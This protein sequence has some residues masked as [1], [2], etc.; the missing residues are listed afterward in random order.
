MDTLIQI[1][2]L[3]A[4][5]LSGFVFSTISILGVD[6]NWIV[7]WLFTG[8]VF[9]TL[10]LGF[11]N[12]RGFSTGLKALRGDFSRTD[13]PG[14]LSP[15]EAL[16]T[17]LSATVGLGNIAGVAIAI[18][19]G[20]PGAAFWMIFIGFFA[21]SLKFAE[22]T[23]AV[24]YREIGVD[25]HIKGGPMYY[26]ERG[27]AEKGWPRFGR[28]MGILYA[29]FALIAFIQVIQVNQSW[30]QINVVLGLENDRTFALV[31]GMCIAT[32]VGLVLIGGVKGVARVTS[33]LTPLMCA[34]YLGSVAI[35]LAVNYDKIGPAM[36]T[37]VTSAFTSE[38]GLGGV[39]GAFVIGMRRAVYSNE[40]GIGSAAIAHATVKTDYPASEG[41]VAILEPFV[42]TFIVCAATAILIVSTGVWDEGY[43]D[44]AMT[45]AAFATVSSWFPVML[46]VC[47][48]VFAFSTMIAAGF[49]GR[50]LASYISNGREWFVNLYLVLFCALL[51][52]GAIV[53]FSTLIK[54]IDSLFFLLSVPN[55]V[56]L[57]LLTSVISV[58]IR[59]FRKARLSGEFS[60]QSMRLE[61]SERQY[62][63]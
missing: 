4:T 15:F 55:L 22:V 12:V 27:F 1:I 45:S 7:L 17:A 60:L 40:A 47:V 38:A 24:R 19:I 61:L 10:R 37:I 31:Y 39:I 54:I 62:D 14:D 41:Y 48:S 28:L 9:F 3:L 30:S 50:Q 35:V 44:I 57:F 52:L 33:R 26:L 20:G 11:I 25:G 36:L 51:P 18:G 58:E 21:M 49:Y 46:A 53:D 34:L 13:A 59:R 56:G 43:G 32:L 29:A 5:S 8:M 16:S 6:V 2:D 63:E 42:D 23:L